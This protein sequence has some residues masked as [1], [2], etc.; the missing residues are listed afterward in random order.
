MI[1][2]KDYIFIKNTRLIYYYTFDKRLS[3]YYIKGSLRTSINF[4]IHYNYICSFV[5]VN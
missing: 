3:E 4:K 2:K 1:S 5:Y